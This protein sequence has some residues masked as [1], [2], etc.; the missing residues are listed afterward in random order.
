MARFEY[1]M[2]D[3]FDTVEQKI[4]DILADNMTLIAPSGESR[5]EDHRTWYSAVR[6]GL[7]AEQRKIVLIK[8]NNTDNIIGF[9]QYYVNFETFMME[10]IQIIPE[11]WGKDSIFR[12]LYDFVLSHIEVPPHYVSAYANKSNEK[13]VSILRHLGLEI[14]E[15]NKNG[16]SYK[17]RGDFSALVI[18]YRS[19]IENGVVTE[20]EL[21]P[22]KIRNIK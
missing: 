3:E 20:Q 11:C 13:S 1:L 2:K 22:R 6:E 19:R 5:D 10:E 16:N 7:K 4:F 14:V 9:F 12:D 8:E 17:L 18:W 15:E 21:K